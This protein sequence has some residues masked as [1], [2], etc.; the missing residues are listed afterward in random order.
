MQK[1]LQNCDCQ[2]NSEST[3]LVDAAQYSKNMST[4]VI[5]SQIPLLPEEGK[6]NKSLFPEQMTD[7]NEQ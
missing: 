7:F 4:S 1:I 3:A 2:E 5:M 6:R